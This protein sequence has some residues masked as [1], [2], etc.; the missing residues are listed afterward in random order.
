MKKERSDVSTPIWKAGGNGSDSLTHYMI[1][2]PTVRGKSLLLQAEADRLGISYEE[3]ERRL[4]PTNEQRDQMRVREEGEER[5]EERRLQ[6]VRQAIWD[7]WSDDDIAFSRI[8]DALVS[9]VMNDP[10]SLAQVKAVF[11]MLPAAIIG[12][13]ISWGFDDTEVGD[14]IHR[15]I[16]E[17][18]EAV[19]AQLAYAKA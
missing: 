14:D 6:A 16:H 10:P 1:M 17:N 13:G 4:E 3:V 8:H 7:A 19:V 15:F 9:T 2:G 18:R 11:M 5:K 12:T